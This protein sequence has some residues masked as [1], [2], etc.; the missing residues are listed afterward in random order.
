MTRAPQNLPRNL[1]ERVHT[2][3]KVRSLKLARWDRL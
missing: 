2:T 1:D 3:A